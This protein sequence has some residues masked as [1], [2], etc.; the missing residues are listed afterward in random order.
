[1]WQPTTDDSW[2]GE[3]RA[4]C[5][6]KVGRQS[7]AVS[8]PLS[9]VLNFMAT[10]GSGSSSPGW[11]K[12]KAGI[13]LVDCSWYNPNM[14]NTGSIQ[15]GSSPLA[16]GWER[17]GLTFK[18]QR[19]TP[20]YQT[21]DVQSFRFMSP[22]LTLMMTVTTVQVTLYFVMSLDSRK[23]VPALTKEWTT[24]FQTFKTYWCKGRI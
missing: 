3:N 5:L 19:L 17:P 11:L 14:E 20:Q 7:F 24:C 9:I 23:M 2:Q 12:F 16:K 8:I 13:A 22:K 15:L 21:D 18:G 1:M 10:T 4:I 6:W